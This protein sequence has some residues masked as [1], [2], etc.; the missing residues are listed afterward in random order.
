MPWSPRVL[1]RVAAIGEYR[2][3]EEEAGASRVA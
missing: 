3:N 2:P 1:R